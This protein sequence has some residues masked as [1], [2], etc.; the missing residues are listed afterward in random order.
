MPTN[1]EIRELLEARKAARRAIPQ[2]D[3]ADAV[4]APPE[5]EMVELPAPTDS[6]ERTTEATG[7]TQLPPV[8]VLEPDDP[9]MASVPPGDAYTPTT[10]RIRN[11]HKR[12]LKAEAYYRGLLMQDIFETALDEYFKKR[13]S[14]DGSIT[15][16]KGGKHG[17]NETHA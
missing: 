13:Y 7:A 17:N 9:R 2:A 5:P 11:H 12:Q 3:P 8:V 14:R 4:G 10:L 6:P 16:A 15:A 1:K